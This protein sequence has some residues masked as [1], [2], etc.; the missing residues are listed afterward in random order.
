VVVAKNAMTTLLYLGANL[1]KK[2]A[3]RNEK[4]N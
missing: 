3:K 2:E 1:E 4:Y